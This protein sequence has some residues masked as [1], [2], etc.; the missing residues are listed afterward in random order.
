[1]ELDRRSLRPTGTARYIVAAFMLVWLAGWAFGEAGALFA[2]GAILRNSVGRIT[3]QMP[4][5][6]SHPAT[7]GAVVFVVLFLTLWLVF[8]T[9]G[10]ITAFVQLLRS[11]W[12]EDVIALAPDGFELIRRAGPFRRRDAF[13]RGSIRR[14]R[15][16]PHDKAIVIDAGKRSR[17]ITF[18]TSDE[19]QAAAD[20]L[21]RSLMLPDEAAMAASAAPPASWNAVEDAGATRLRKGSVIRTE[22]IVRRG[23]LTFRRTILFF[24]SERV[25]RNARLEITHDTSSENDNVYRLVVSDGEARKTLDVQLLDSSRVVDLGYW[26][27]ARTGFPFAPNQH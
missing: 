20:W 22:L 23:E 27:A 15:L 26:L 10:G 14:I 19:R 4:D 6:M 17:T 9:L 3:E 1:M 7:T 8:W 5:W 16:R 24:P 25:F 2:I 11:L 21:T 12:G 13:D 18:G